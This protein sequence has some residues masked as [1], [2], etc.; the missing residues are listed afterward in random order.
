M[1]NLLYS[2]V[3]ITRTLLYSQVQTTRNLLYSQVCI[4]QTLLYGQVQTT[5]NLLYNQVCI[6]QTLLYG[7][8]WITQTLLYSE[9]WTTG[10][11]LYSQ[12]CITRNLLYSQVCITPLM[13]FEGIGGSSETTL[14]SLSSEHSC[15]VLTE[16]CV[17]VQSG[18][19]ALPSVTMVTIG[20]LGDALYH[21]G[22]VSVQVMWRGPVLPWL[23]YKS[24][25]AETPCVA[26]VTIQPQRLK[27]H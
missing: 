17:K 22:T 1:R 18:D 26:V 3:C 15:Q 13:Q 8:V 4:T 2:Q 12:V 24:G 16:L 6:T 7:Q 25:H 9:V 20:S 19:A 21:N 14:H 11:L 23:R 5:R 10:T 27:S